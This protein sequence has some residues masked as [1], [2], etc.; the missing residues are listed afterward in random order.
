[1]T[2]DQIK[3]LLARRIEQCKE[4]QCNPDFAH[5]S[6]SAFTECLSFLDQLDEWTPVE[7]G[8]P[9]EHKRVL[10][11]A[12]DWVQSG[13]WIQFVQIGWIEKGQWDCAS[14]GCYVEAWMNA[15]QPWG[16]K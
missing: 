5:G 11:S 15:P 13:E 16:G 1:M 7:K 12:R 2:I 9:E 8:L 3:A 10:V 14:D 4:A 6:E